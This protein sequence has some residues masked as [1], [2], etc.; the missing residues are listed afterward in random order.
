MIAMI[1]VHYLVFFDPE[2]DPFG[3]AACRGQSEEPEMS[4]RPNPIDTMLL[5]FVRRCGR[6]RSGKRGHSSDLSRLQRSM[7]RVSSSEYCVVLRPD[8][9]CPF[10]IVHSKLCRSPA[11]CWAWNPYQ[12]ISLSQQRPVRLSLV[13]PCVPRMAVQYRTSFRTDSSQGLFSLSPMGARMAACPSVY[14]SCT[15]AC[16]HGANGVL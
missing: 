5:G 4:F 6:S 10:S 11:D 9:P 7:I 15:S 3:N 13:H 8:W 16:R 1:L 12:R 2:L 14:L